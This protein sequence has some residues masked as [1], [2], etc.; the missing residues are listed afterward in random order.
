MTDLFGAVRRAP[1]LRLG[2]QYLEGAEACQLQMAKRV[3]TWLRHVQRTLW[4]PRC[5]LCGG[6]GQLP[7]IDLCSGC[8][9]DIQRNVRACI[10][11]AEPLSGVAPSAG[12]LQCGACL[13]KPPRFDHTLCPFLYSYPLDHLVRGLKYRGRV[14]YGR[15]LGE[16]LAREVAARS[17]SCPLPQAIIPVPLAPQRFRE[18]GYN[19]AIEL[20]L[21]IERSS[22]IALRTDVV[23][24]TRETQEQ[25]GLDRRARRRNIKG[26]FSLR[27]PPALRHVAIVD[28]VL[29]TGSTVNEMA[30]M[31]KR[32]GVKRVEVWAVART[33]KF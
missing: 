30:R 2:Q 9:G 24:R 20:A 23:E 28:D 29:T 1:T 13:R 15:I 7:V 26:A 31:L 33:A 3:D 10:R 17:S 11:C 32:A 18:R 21:H 4:P 27:M 8:A 12:A 14:A 19:Q 5:V 25:A 22:G 16:M 6:T